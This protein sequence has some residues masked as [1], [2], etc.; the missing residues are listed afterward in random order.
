M[1]FW[2]LSLITLAAT[3]A[4]AQSTPSTKQESEVTIIGRRA[5]DGAELLRQVD[6]IAGHPSFDKPLA[7]FTDPV[8]LG[9]MGLDSKS[10]ALLLDRMVQVAEAAH[11]PMNGK[12][13]CI[14]NV[15]VLFI[16]DSQS[17]IKH[18]AK[19]M[20]GLL[21][22]LSYS[23]IKALIKEP[24]PAYAWSA[25]E[26]R[27]RDGDRLGMGMPGEVAGPGE[28]P[29]LRV[30]TA[31]RTAL[32]IRQDMLSSVVI[33]ERKAVQG[34]LIIQIADYAAMRAFVE[35]KPQRNAGAPTILTLFDEGVVAPTEMTAFDRGYL[36]GTYQGEGNNLP[37]FQMGDMARAIGAE[38]AKQEP[39][40]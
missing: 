40:P 28:V 8:C 16:D 14:P 24:G 37:S 35:T 31:T 20:S 2:I 12:A 27:S 3:G 23:E 19:R 7:R 6:A 18:I 11:V 15:L 13:K 9:T 17:A 33:I 5:P 39:S 36:L 4:T 1:R 30:P 22:S 34:K 10:G 32:S 29:T 38:L 25:V 26:T 21:R